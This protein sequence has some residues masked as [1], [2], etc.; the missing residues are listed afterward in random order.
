MRPFADLTGQAALVTGAGSAAGPG[1]ACARLLGR[2]GARVAISSTTERIHDRVAELLAL[3]IYAFGVPADLTRSEQATAL[4][5]AMAERRCRVDMLV[6]NA[7]MTS[8]SRPAEAAPSRGSRTPLSAKR[9][10][11]TWPPRSSCALALELAPRG[12]RGNAVCPADV[13]TPLLRYQA[14]TFGGGDPEGYRRRLRENY[15]Q[16]ARARFLRPEEAAG[17]T[18]A[19]VSIDFGLSAGI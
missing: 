6:N 1:F 7:G 11:E 18:G 12:I 3:G 2:L 10:R 16:G 14:E 5:A 8:V 15:P 4:V 19:N 9:C 13:E 17:I